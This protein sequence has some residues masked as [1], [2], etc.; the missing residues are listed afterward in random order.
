V[1]KREREVN[2]INAS[3]AHD[4]EKSTNETRGYIPLC[5]AVHP[6]K[7]VRGNPMKRILRGQSPVERVCARWTT[8]IVAVFHLPSFLHT[9]LPLFAS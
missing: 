3:A 9:F 8:I 5:N 2:S 4:G 7:E 6:R 1:R